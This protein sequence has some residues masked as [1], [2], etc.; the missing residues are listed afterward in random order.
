VR[1][2]RQDCNAYPLECAALAVL[3]SS[4]GPASGEWRGEWSPAVGVSNPL[5]FDC[6]VT[7][8]LYVRRGAFETQGLPWVRELASGERETLHFELRGGS[9]SPGGDPLLAAL[10]EWPALGERPAGRLL[11]DLPLRRRR[12]AVADV[13]T[14]RLEMLRESPEALR[15]S[16]ILTRRGAELVVAVENS[17]GLRDTRALVRIDGRTYLGGSRLRLP[18]PVDFD[19]LEAGVSFA[20][21]FYGRAGEE[22][23]ELLRRWSG[24]LPADPGHGG[25]GRLL[26]RRRL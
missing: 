7:A 4:D 6:R 20:C 25:E 3:T 10:Y 22:P 14:Q 2:E 18:L 11:L 12:F 24:G 8:Q 21:G 5:P 19:A 1:L 13:I 26:A 17:G 16:M 23:S 15:A 9:W